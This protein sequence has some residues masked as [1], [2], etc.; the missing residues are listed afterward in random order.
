[1]ATWH[2]GC[3]IVALRKQRVREEQHD[4]EFWVMFFLWRRW[5]PSM[6]QLSRHATV[7]AVSSGRPLDQNCKYKRISTDVF[8]KIDHSATFRLILYSFW[9]LSPKGIEKN[10]CA[11]RTVYLLINP[12]AARP[13][14]IRN[15]T[16]SAGID[17]IRQNLTS[18]DVR[19]WRLYSN[20]TYSAGIDLILTSI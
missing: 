9:E 4:R 6:P 18:I 16:Y 14:Y 8:R 2:R 7:R 19:L 3:V 10:P 15:N 5:Y 17:F 1:M 20:N 12:Y 13:L 11:T